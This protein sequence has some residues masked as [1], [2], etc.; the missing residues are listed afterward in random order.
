M[1]QLD[2]YVIIELSNDSCMV[3]RFYL[4]YSVKISIWDDSRMHHV[5]DYFI[6]WLGFICLR[7]YLLVVKICGLDF[8]KV[9]GTRYRCPTGWPGM[10]RHDVGPARSISGRAVTGHRASRAVPLRASWLAFGPGTALWAGFRAVPAREA[11]QILRAG[12]A[13][14]PS[15]LKYLKTLRHI[16]VS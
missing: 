11:R 9:A 13:H 12:P 3:F 15:T 4:C 6:C 8:L 7:Y 10:A 5:W 2:F 14:S 1:I 16:S